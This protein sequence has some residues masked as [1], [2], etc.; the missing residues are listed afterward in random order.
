[1]ETFVQILLR[2]LK[3]NSKAVNK[4]QGPSA[5]Q[6]YKHQAPEMDPGACSPRA[7]LP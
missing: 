4:G 2:I 5:V 6:L 1:M 3:R 7:R